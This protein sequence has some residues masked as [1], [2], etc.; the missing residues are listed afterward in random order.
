MPRRY[1]PTIQR[2]VNLTPRLSNK[3]DILLAD[4]NR[5]GKVMYGGFSHLVEHLLQKFFTELEESKE[6]DDDTP[7]S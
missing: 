7:N 4:E 5:Q 6:L 2:K 3:V 1:G